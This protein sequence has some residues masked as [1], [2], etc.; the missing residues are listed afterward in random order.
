[1]KINNGFNLRIKKL[2]KEKQKI[3]ITI[4]RNQK[5]NKETTLI[6]EARAGALKS[7]LKQVKP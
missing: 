2:K 4:S 6:N 5:A 3:S 7:S 1:M